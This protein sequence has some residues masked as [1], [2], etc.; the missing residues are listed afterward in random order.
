MDL[1]SLLEDKLLILYVATFATSFLSAII[2]MAGGVTLLSIMTFFL[3]Y[4]Q[5]IPIHGTTQLMSNLSR[6]FFLRNYLHKKITFAFILG[7]PIGAALVTLFLTKIESKTVPYVL[8]SLLIFYAVFKPK[9]LPTIKM[10]PLAF[11]IVGFVAG[12]LGLVVGATGPFLAPLLLGQGMEKQELIATKAVLQASV[13]L[14]KIPSF[15]Y[16]GFN[17]LDNLSLIILLALI[18]TVGTKVGVK[19]LFKIN[20]KLF[21]YLFKGVLL[22]SA[23][24]LLYKVFI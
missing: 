9:K 12:G 4:Q 21:F 14:L 16:I 22:I 8:I 1:S 15:L 18:A 5:L 24:R 17:Y 3:P 10:P 2:G 6:A 19:V 7:A 23:F 13:H 11:F 20:D